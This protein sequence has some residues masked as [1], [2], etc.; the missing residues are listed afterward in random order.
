MSYDIWLVADLGGPEPI[1]VWDSWNY[2]SN[3][4]PM[5]RKAMP[6]TDG[7]AGM[8]NRRAGDMA[9]VLARGIAAME[10][11][12][13]PYRAMNPSNKWGDFDQQL[14]RLRWMLDAFRWAPNAYV[15]VSR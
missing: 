13:E 5:W 2:T 4:A 6:E 3:V 11:D 8:H 14:A 9:Y 15:R 10:A 12:P 7:L 1:T